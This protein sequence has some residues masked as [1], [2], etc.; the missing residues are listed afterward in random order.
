[1]HPRITGTSRAVQLLIRRMN[2]ELQDIRDY[3]GIPEKDQKQQTKPIEN[4][5]AAHKYRTPI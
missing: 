4:Y 3:G 5:C 2:E 1:M